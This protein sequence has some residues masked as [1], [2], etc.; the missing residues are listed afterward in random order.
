MGIY[1]KTL[2]APD[3]TVT[4]SLH[5]VQQLFYADLPVM[6]QQQVN[7]DDLATA[8]TAYPDPGV[9]A[10]QLAS[11]IEGTVSNVTGLRS[12]QT[13]IDQ[14]KSMT[15]IF[16]SIIF[17]V[18][19]ISLLVGGL[20]VVNTMTM[21]VLER[22]REIGIRKAIGA[23]HRQIISQFL[24]ESGLHRLPRRGDRAAAGL[25]HRDGRERPDGTERH[26]PLP[27][28]PAPGH[29][30]RGL[31]DRPGCGERVLPLLPRGAA[32]AGPGPEVR[33]MAPADERPRTQA[34]RT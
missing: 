27:G 17:G 7:P 25:D 3:N 2:T 8:I 23:S 16:N 9:D 12:R 22:T 34:H 18:A 26:G 21:S 6:V 32:Q 29:R 10:D 33:M 20:S 15:K 11:T 28:D 5:D 30:R 4:I 19:L 31:R 14:F 24:G 1:D 13:F